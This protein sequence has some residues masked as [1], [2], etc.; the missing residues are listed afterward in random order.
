M[1]TRIASRLV[2]VLALVGGLGFA[3]DAHSAAN[4]AGLTFKAYY[5]SD[6]GCFSS[7]SYGAIVNNCP[8]AR[9]LSTSLPVPGGWHGTNVSIYGNGSMC[10]TV[11]TNGVGNG[12]NIGAETW[13]VAGPK[14]WQTLNTGDR[15]VWDSSP[16]VFRCLLESGGVVGSFTAL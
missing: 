8:D 2:P 6:A 9:W 15:Y 1:F 11:S 7:S 13:T 10:Q 12:A 14:T 3:M 5:P 16:V 4:G